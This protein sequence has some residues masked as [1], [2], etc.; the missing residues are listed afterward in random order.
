LLGT[1]SLP[2]DSG[3]FLVQESFSQIGKLP[4]CLFLPVL[5][6]TA[7][8]LNVQV[9]SFAKLIFVALDYALNFGF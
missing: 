2:F 8:L 5:L 7:E 4:F 3:F 9:V 1:F 6:A